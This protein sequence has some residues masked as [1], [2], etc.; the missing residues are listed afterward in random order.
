MLIRKAPR[1]KRKTPQADI[2]RRFSYVMGIDIFNKTY[3][4][5]LVKIVRTNFLKSL[6]KIEPMFYNVNQNKC[7]EHLYTSKRK[8]RS[9]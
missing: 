8:E 7:A 1:L 3:V 2:L 5:F 9:E 6:D 4:A